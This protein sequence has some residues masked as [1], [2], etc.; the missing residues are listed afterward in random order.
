VS[1]YDDRGKRQRKL[2]PDQATAEAEA[3]K[4]QRKMNKG[5]Q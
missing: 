5:I 4:L 1:Y 2:F 3:E